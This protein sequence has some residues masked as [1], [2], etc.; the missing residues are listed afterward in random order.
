MRFLG[1]SLMGLFLVCITI[2]FLSA[3][4]KTFYDAVQAKA[5]QSG[6]R[7]P[8]RE[9]QFAVNAISVE[10]G[11]LSP[12]LSAFGEVRARRML[13][14]RLSQ[15]GEIIEISSSFEEGGAVK[16]G[17]TLLRID[18]TDAQSA[19]QVAQADL[20]E[21]T[22]ELNDAERGLEIAIDDLEA[23][24]AQQALRND[25]LAR[26]RNLADRGVGTKASVE[27]AAL[28]EAAAQQAVL[29]KRQSLA[30]ATSRVDQGK[31]GVLRSEIVLA[32]AQRTLDETSLVAGFDGTLSGVTGALGTILTANEQLGSLIDPTDL[33]VS[34]RVSTQQ[35]ARMSGSTGGVPAL[36][37][38]VSLDT[39]GVDLISTGQISRESAA[40]ESGQT[41]RLLFASLDTSRGLRSGDFVTVKVQERALEGVAF[42]PSSAVNA[43][44][45]VL[46][47]TRDNRLEVVEAPVLRR[48]GDDVIVDASK[49]VGLRL[50][51]EQSPLLG[52][53]IRVSI[54]GEPEAPR[55]E[56]LDVAQR[57][58]ES[59]R[60]GA[61][62]RGAE[63]AG[64]ETIALTQERRTTLLAFIESNQRMPDE[65]R[66][67]LKEQ[68][69]APEVSA[70]V[71][72]RLESRMGN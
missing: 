5:E 58:K 44:G 11:T 63:R 40:V 3:A 39:S 10:S 61:P 23:A 1:R 45:T 70:A 37:V 65:M 26:Q 69:S 32:N 21:A 22:V 52:A 56:N 15:G 2:G 49:L 30:T 46:S 4:G 68:L 54:N 24:Q 38:Q 67:Q 43:A 36:P 34:F 20:Q 53:G 50:V 27:T 28:S 35:Y 62:E 9:R 48:Q 25:A 31:N 72:A 6:F 12:E 59:A 17:E 66:A 18:P 8:A 14:L 13:E 71:V 16:K 41:G 42:L 29:S 51:A 19:L 47:I 60:G 7:P 57:E 33:E 55:G 64:G